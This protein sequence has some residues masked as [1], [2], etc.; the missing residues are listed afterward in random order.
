MSHADQFKDKVRGISLNLIPMS[1][2]ILKN[3]L[4][5]VLDIGCGTGILSF[6]SA[7]AGARRGR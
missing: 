5:V 6:F 4:K 3:V 7:A 2:N 1:N